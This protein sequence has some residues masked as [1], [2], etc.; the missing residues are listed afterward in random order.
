LRATFD[1]KMGDI[2]IRASALIF[3][4]LPFRIN[5]VEKLF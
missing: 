3:L 2:K 1:R 4:S 5:G